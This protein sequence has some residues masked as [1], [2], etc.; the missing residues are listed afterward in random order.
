MTD[1][2]ESLLV[3]EDVGVELVLDLGLGPGL[4]L[5]LGSLALGGLSALGGARALIFGRLLCFSLKEKITR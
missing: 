2:G 1:F 3:Q 5:S 4:L